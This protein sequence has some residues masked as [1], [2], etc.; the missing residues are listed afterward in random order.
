MYPGTERILR[1][2]FC[3]ALSAPLW[4]Q[5]FRITPTE[6]SSAK[7]VEVPILL[8]TAA[9]KQPAALQW[10]CSFPAQQLK[11]AGN[12]AAG[13]A[14]VAAGKTLKCA[15]RWKKAPEVFAYEC[16]L[17]G[18]MK[19]IGN[20]PIAVLRFRVPANA[21]KGAA[22]IRVEGQGASPDSGKLAIAPGEG[23]VTVR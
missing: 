8:E 3:I 18:G 9:G 23:I 12:P 13:A 21:R 10:E 5:A 7:P 15:G 2:A 11:P 19:P 6:A 4:A 14:A 1:F 17:A 22:R 16:I 20:G